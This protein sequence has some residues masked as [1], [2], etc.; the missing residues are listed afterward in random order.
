MHWW[1]HILIGSGF[2]YLFIYLIAC[3]FIV[4]LIDY[5]WISHCAP[6]CHSFPSTTVSILHP[7]NLPAREDRKKKNILT[8]KFAVCHIVYTFVQTALFVNVYCTE[9]L[10]W[11]KSSGFCY[12]NTGLLETFLCPFAV[13][14]CHGNPTALVLQDWLLHALL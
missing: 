9:T 14:L 4:F 5:L 3:L 13:F 11:F 10:V 6:Q 12:T 7:C 2:A 1:Q 8:V